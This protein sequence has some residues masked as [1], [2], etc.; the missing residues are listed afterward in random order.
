MF[1]EKIISDIERSSLLEDVHD[2][3]KVIVTYRTGSKVY[4]SHFAVR[5]D[6]VS[7]FMDSAYD[8]FNNDAVIQFNGIF[9]Q[10]DPRFW[11]IM[12]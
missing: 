4:T 5:T 7:S 6:N 11:F 10:R 3:F 2:F 8:S 12:V 1:M 9:K